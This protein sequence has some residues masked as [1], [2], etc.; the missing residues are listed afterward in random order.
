M[1]SAKKEN[2]KCCKRVLKKGSGSVWNGVNGSL[3]PEIMTLNWDIIYVTWG[4]DVCHPGTQGPYGLEHK[5]REM[6]LQINHLISVLQI[7]SQ[8]HWVSSCPPTKLHWSFSQISKTC[9][10]ILPIVFIK[11]LNNQIGN[12]L[13]L[14]SVRILVVSEWFLKGCSIFGLGPIIHLLKDLCRKEKDLILHCHY[15]R[16]V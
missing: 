9:L 3:F 15:L 14:K 4:K 5:E 1:L 8:G 12:S 10:V 13:F 2:T 11:S 6:R 16:T 7:N